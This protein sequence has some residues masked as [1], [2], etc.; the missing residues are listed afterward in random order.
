[1]LDQGKSPR[2]IRRAIDEKYIAAMDSA[3]P[4]PYP[5]A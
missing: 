2:A 1:M 3:T 4:T 5:P